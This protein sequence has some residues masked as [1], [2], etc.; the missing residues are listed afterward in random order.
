MKTKFMLFLCFLLS[1]CAQKTRL[2][3]SIDKAG[4]DL[5][6]N[7]TYQQKIDIRYKRNSKSNFESLALNGVLKKT[8]NKLLV[9]GYYAFGISLFKI[10]DTPPKAI[11]FEAYD[12]RIE[13]N[14]ALFL[15]FYSALKE[16]FM[17]KKS[18]K[19]LI[20][21]KFQVNVKT[22]EVDTVADVQIQNLGKSI[23]INI[24]PYFEMHIS[25]IS[26]DNRI[27]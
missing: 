23:S 9:Y 8:N 26:V 11:D 4:D 22:N 18:D 17:M 7:G 19:R 10:E 16:V 15:Q 12:S 14:K 1:A 27:E 25:S 5:F 20:K 24:S 3:E 2:A 13:K 6:S 21:E